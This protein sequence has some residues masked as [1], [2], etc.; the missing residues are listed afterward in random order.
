[1]NIDLKFNIGDSVYHPDGENVKQGEIVSSRVEVWTTVNE[2][3]YTKITY[4]IRTLGKTGYHRDSS[5]WPENELFKTKEECREYIALKA[6]KK[7]FDKEVPGNVEVMKRIV[8]K[9][10]S[11]IKEKD[12]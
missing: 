1:M 7:M 5:D 9:L 4:N 6:I 10:N 11:Y 2:K 12:V 8:D 3:R